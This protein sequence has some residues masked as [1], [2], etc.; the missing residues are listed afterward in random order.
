M[1]EQENKEM[2][3]QAQQKLAGEIEKVMLHHEDENLQW[4]GTTIDLME[5]AYVAFTTCKLQNDEG[6]YLS[7]ISIARNVCRILHVTLPANPYEVAARGLRRK[8]FRRHPFMDRYLLKI[9]RQPNS[10]PL[11]EQIA[12]AANR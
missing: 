7:F 4:Q 10:H 3:R 5:A 9:N 6:E 11:W 2:K 12:P 1:N 8:G